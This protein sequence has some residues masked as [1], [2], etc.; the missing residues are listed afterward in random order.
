MPSSGE[1]GLEEKQVQRAEEH[2]ELRGCSHGETREAAR[3]EC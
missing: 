3:P 2:R 1:A